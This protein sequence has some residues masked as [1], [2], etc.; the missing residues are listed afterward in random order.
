[1]ITLNLLCLTL[2]KSF[3]IYAPF[4]NI[5]KIKQEYTEYLEERCILITNELLSL[6][7]A[8]SVL[9]VIPKIVFT[10]FALQA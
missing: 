4:D 10:F 1:M 8:I 3:L 7:S 2:K 9:S 6:F 5:L